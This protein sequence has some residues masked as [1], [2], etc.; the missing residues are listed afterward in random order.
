MNTRRANPLLAQSISG[1]VDLFYDAEQGSSLRIST[2][3]E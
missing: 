2:S 3:A 1:S